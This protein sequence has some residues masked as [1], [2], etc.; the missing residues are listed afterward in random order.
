MLD[1][2][3]IRDNADA[4]KKGV[5]DRNM[6]C[7]VDR[8]LSLYDQI[9]KHR[10]A[11]DSANTCIKANQNSVRAASSEK[12]RA[13]LVESGKRLK[14]EVAELK[15]SIDDLMPEYNALMLSVP[16]AM[17]DD[18][19]IGKSD[20]LNVEVEVWSR[21]TRFEFEPKNHIELGRSLDLL[22][23]SAGAKVAGTKFYFMKNEA[24][25]LDLALQ[26]YAI[27]KL[28]KKGYTPLI[29]PDLAKDDILRGSG[30]NPRGSERNTYSIE[31][32]DLN[33]IATAEITVGGML[34]NTILNYEDLPKKYVAF[35]HCF[36]TEAGAAGRAAYGLYRVH[37]FSKVEMYQFVKSEDGESA[38]QELLDIEKEIYSELGIPYRVI[39]ICSGDLGAPA[40]KKYDI[41]AWMPGKGDEGEYGEV[42]SVGNFTDF[43]SRRLNIKYIDKNGSRKFVTTLNG[44]AVATGR[45]ILAIMENF[46][47]AD[48]SIG[49]P[50]A[51]I[52]YTGFSEIAPKTA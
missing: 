31:G 26:T 21:P 37:Q 13:E 19:P 39:R 52:P 5:F 9:L 25:L 17:A 30:F 4:V 20:D 24:V 14:Q 10:Q 11:I 50:E 41:E 1:I 2:K 18:T 28:V 15:S 46:Q 16:N 23:F 44:T 40:Y 51:L 36:R 43:Q 22:D 3:Y 45:I 49:I 33:L 35:S 27:N 29:T 6:T 48:G 7:D 12:E 8:L 47:R 42:T 34:S 32:L 38:L